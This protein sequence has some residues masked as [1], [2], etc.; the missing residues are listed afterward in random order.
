MGVNG[1]PPP[2]QLS[3]IRLDPKMQNSPDPAPAKF[4]S[5][6]AGAQPRNFLQRA[7]IFLSILAF[8]SA[9]RSAAEDKIVSPEEQSGYY[10]ESQVQYFYIK[11]PR[12]LSYDYPMKISRD[13]G[14]PL[15]DDT[16]V[17]THLVLADPLNACEPLKQKSL[18]KSQYRDTVVLAIRGDCSFLEK[19]INIQNAGAY[20]AFIYNN[21]AKDEFISMAQD[22]TNRQHMVKIA[23]YFIYHSDGIA[24]AE[25]LAS[26]GNAVI[27][28]PL[29]GTTRR[30]RHPPWRVW[31]A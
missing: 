30:V 20:A 14:G 7:T 12:I 29:N 22:E 23:P 21:E 13:F 3:Q 1:D 28:L 26:G 25:S 24:I 18:L 10:V 15:S 6:C 16:P 5:K 9:R 19:T 8:Y 17:S 2:T 27:H 31:T 11:S 4:R